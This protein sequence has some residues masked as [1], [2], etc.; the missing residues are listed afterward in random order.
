M[1]A[2]ADDLV[3]SEKLT[4]ESINKELAALG[5]Q[6]ATLTQVPTAVI[7]N[8]DPIDGSASSLRAVW[9]ALLAAIGVA[10]VV[11]AHTH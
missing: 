8:P 10:S 11:L 4:L 6:A 7:A 2:E 5:I 9:P 1:Q 3:Q